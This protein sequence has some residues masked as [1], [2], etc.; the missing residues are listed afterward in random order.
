[1]PLKSTYAIMETLKDV[2]VV[3]ENALRFL[4]ATWTMR[5][6]FLLPRMSSEKLAVHAVVIAPVY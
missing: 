1:M 5:V 2:I 3:T 6:K 4:L